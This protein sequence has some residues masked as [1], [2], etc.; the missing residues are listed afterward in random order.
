MGTV[1]TET[2]YHDAV[3]NGVP[4]RV[5]DTTREVI[6]V[7]T[8]NQRL[9]NHFQISPMSSPQEARNLALLLRAGAFPAPV[10]YIE[11][12]IIGPSMG[13]ENIKK[14]V[15]SLVAGLALVLGFMM[16]YY[17]VF[18]IISNIALLMNLVSPRC[19]FVITWRHLD[20]A[21]HGGNCVDTGDGGRCERLDL[22]ADP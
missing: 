19:R 11:E 15:I 1:F 5:A 9:D 8:I 20:T 13:E 21:Q 22:R 10:D 12:R 6:N 3:V 17:S 2:R 4:T 14:G 7:A 16:C 18:G